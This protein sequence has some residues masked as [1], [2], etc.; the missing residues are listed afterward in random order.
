MIG[1][2]LEWVGLTYYGMQVDHSV[3]LEDLARQEPDFYRLSWGALCHLPT[4]LDLM[5]QIDK[6]NAGDF[7]GAKAD[8]EAMRDGKVAEL[9]TYLTG[10]SATLE[11]VTPQINAL[12]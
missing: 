8:L 9:N 10:F 3:Y 5:P 1:W 4:W 7:A 6:V 12:K 11:Q 2:N